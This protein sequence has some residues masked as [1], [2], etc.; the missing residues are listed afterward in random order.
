MDSGVSSPIMI[1]LFLLFFLF[2][3]FLFIF[4]SRFFL[5]FIYL[6]LF[7]P[8]VFTFLKIH[9]SPPHDPALLAGLTTHQG[10]PPQK[11]GVSIYSPT[12]QQGQNV[13]QGQFFYTELKATLLFTHNWWENDR[14]YS[15][16]KSINPIYQPLRSG[17]I[18]LNVNF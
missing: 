11:R 12:L 3:L 4:L 5:H 16:P 8:S 13:T 10:V 14:T 9:F 1:L 7:F 2:H 6:M 18:W 17:R 15:F